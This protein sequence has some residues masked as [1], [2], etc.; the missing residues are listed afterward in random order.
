M[1]QAEKSQKKQ[2]ETQKQKAGQAQLEEEQRMDEGHGNA[3]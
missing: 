1:E 3:D 2:A